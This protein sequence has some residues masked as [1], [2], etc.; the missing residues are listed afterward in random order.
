MRDKFAFRFLPRNGGELVRIDVLTDVLRSMTAGLRHMSEK[1]AAELAE[2]L[3]ADE[4][5]VIENLVPYVGPV[6]GGSLVVPVVF[7]R[8]SSLVFDQ[9]HELPSLFAMQSSE[10]LLRAAGGQGHDVPIRAAEAFVDASRHAAKDDCRLLFVSKRAQEPS[11]SP[12][13][14]LSSIEGDLERYIERQA[15]RIR[16]KVQIIGRIERLTL[17]PL[18]VTVRG[19]R[20]ERRVSL[21]GG[22]REAARHLWGHNVLIDA[23]AAIRGDGS[24]EEPHGFRL[25]DLDTMPSV[26]DAFSPPKGPTPR[27][28]PEAME[29]YLS[30]IRRGDS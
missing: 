22:L 2:R 3:H 15:T 29:A 30:D 4:K 17:D 19:P 23:E 11:W 18:T 16:G 12:L 25:L 9:G 10:G 6:E 14:D 20:W 27:V 5:S 13:V 28:D 8:S 21:E 24:I 26:L 7:P 1:M